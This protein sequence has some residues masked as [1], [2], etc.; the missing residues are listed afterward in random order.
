MIFATGNNLT[1][2]GDM[3]RRAVICTLDAGIER[4]ELRSFESD[5]IERVAADRGAYIA[6][7]L[8]ISLAYRAAGSPKVCGPVGSYAQWS[9]AVRAP[10]IGL[11][12]PDPVDSME[13]ARAED[14]E[15]SAIR[16]LFGFWRE[17]LSLNEGFKA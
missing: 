11:G 12:Q 2:V 6:A 7:I 13:T 1:L 8:T 3:V 14:P 9:A 5:P 10:L 16:E 4:P 15:L 17:H